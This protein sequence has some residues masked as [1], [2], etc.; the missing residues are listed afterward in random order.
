MFSKMQQEM[1]FGEALNFKIIIEKIH[2]I[3]DAFRKVVNEKSRK[4][5]EDA[6]SL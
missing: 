5:V 2:K 3:Q 6:S 4:E 1:F